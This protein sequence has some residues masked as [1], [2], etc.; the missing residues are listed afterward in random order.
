MERARAEVL[1][2]QQRRLDENGIS[3]ARRTAV[4]VRLTPREQRILVMVGQGL[5]NRD[6]A[7]ALAISEKTVK[8]HLYSVFRKLG[9]TSRTEAALL[10]GR[11]PGTGL[12]PE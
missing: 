6:I 12:P 1:S 9:V 11:E 8:N 4:R 7:R 3:P 2:E 5:A 10:I